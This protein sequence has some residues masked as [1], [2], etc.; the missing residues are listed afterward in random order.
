MTE[1]DLRCD[2]WEESSDGIFIMS[3]DVQS[4]IGTNYGWAGSGDIGV[5]A[6]YSGMD[7]YIFVVQGFQM[8]ELKYY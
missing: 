1:A 2:K 8:T 3:C 7:N 6:R 4:Q 5:T